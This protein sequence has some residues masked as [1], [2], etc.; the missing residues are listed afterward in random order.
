MTTTHVFVLAA[1]IALSFGASNVLA[2]SPSP[3]A[4]PTV[5]GV[6][7][8]TLQKLHDGDQM[9]IQMGKLAQ[10]KGS[11]RA[12]RSY[13]GQL[14][15]DHSLAERKLDA[16][17][18]KRGSDLGALASTTSA[19][20]DHELLA[21]KSGVDFDRA[22]AMQMVSDHQKTLDLLES[23]RVETGDDALHVLY[24]EL[25]VTV[26]AHKRAAEALLAASAGS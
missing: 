9:E 14:V 8:A 4:P 6:D 16:Y 23:A 25:T 20:P 11:T 12:V 13:G 2:A 7:K 1:V 10:D 18:R 3:L 21:T 17:L 26:R 24:D 22:F 19:D 15:T 5:A